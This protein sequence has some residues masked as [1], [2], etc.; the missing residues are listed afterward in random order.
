LKESTTEK[1]DKF[2]KNPNTNNKEWKN[3]ERNQQGGKRE[4]KP[5]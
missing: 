5:Q 4:E 3:K 1:R 2:R